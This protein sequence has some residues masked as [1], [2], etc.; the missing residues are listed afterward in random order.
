MISA[1]T[2]K[3]ATSQPA[4]EAYAAFEAIYR[5]ITDLPHVTDYEQ[6]SEQDRALFDQAVVAYDHYLDALEEGQQ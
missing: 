5:K 2:F 6:H 3:L 4:R 1:K